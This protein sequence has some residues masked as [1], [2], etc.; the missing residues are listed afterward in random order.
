MK[1][2]FDLVGEFHEKFGMPVAT[3]KTRVSPEKIPLKQF[4][5]RFGFHM[6]ELL[7]FWSGY[8]SRTYVDMA[9]AIIDEAYVILGT[10][11]FCGIYL[12]DYEFHDSERA[13]L[14]HVS[15]ADVIGDLYDTMVSA[16]HDIY[17]AYMAKMYSH[18]RMG[19]A[20]AR[21]YDSVR[22]ASLRLGLPWHDLF[23]EVQRA[24]ITKERAT[25]TDDPRSKR[26][27]AWDIVKPEG[28][29]PPDIPGVFRSVNRAIVWE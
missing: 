22:L 14:S 6:E 8:E 16:Q 13:K 27:S 18:D 15:F 11:H 1:R 25:G 10:A 19:A 20:L 9:D 5:F 12:P 4:L 2:E 17:D 24:N 3:A 21:A 28:W 23:D 26:G 29:T 7:E